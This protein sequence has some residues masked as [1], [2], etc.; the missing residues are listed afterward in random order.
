[1]FTAT[2]ANRIAN[3]YRSHAKDETMTYLEKAIIARAKDGF[4]WF[5][6]DYAYAMSY[7]GLTANEKQEIIFEL[8]SAGYEVKDH[9]MIKQVII[10][11]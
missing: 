9:W 3:G 11:W 10:R 1:M 8:R 6:W 2:E 7:D 5:P 4:K